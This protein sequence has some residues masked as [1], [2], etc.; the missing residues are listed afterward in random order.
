MCSSVASVHNTDPES[1]VR[2]SGK[3]GAKM[4]AQENPKLTSFLGHTNLP[5]H[6]EEQFL[7]KN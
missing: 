4:A 2:F 7:L 5:K 3:R 6:I 1:S